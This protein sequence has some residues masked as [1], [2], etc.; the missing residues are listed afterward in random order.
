MARKTKKQLALDNEVATTPV[1]P[2]Q[3]LNKPTI[4]MG[5]NMSEVQSIIDY[6]EDLGNAEA[7][8]PLPIG[9]YTADIRS[10]EVRTSPKGNQYIAVAFY[11]SPDS[12]PA[13]FTEGNADG[14]TLTFMR[15]SPENTIRARYQMKK[16]CEAIGA[17]LGKTID[18]NDWIGL[19]AV[20]EVAHSTYEGDARAEIKKVK[21]A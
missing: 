16:F 15:L 11:I 20:V 5:N 3:P 2:K 10:A 18:L 8:V 19:T 4:A 7:P 13:D 17:K 12:Y 1:E 14:E 21:E 6:N 9:D